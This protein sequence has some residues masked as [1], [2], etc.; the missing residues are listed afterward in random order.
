MS[1]PP[2]GNDSQ[3]MRDIVI[4]IL[5]IVLLVLANGVFAMA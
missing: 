4:E 3:T 2:V 5:I 1:Y